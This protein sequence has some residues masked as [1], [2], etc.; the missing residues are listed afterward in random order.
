MIANSQLMN[1]QPKKKEGTLLMKKQI[2]IFVSMAA[3]VLGN[4]TFAFAENETMPTGENKAPSVVQEESNVVQEEMPTNPETVTPTSENI[5]TQDE[6]TEDGLPLLQPETVEADTSWFDDNPNKKEFKLSTEAQLLGLAQLVNT[7]V[8]EWQKNEAQTFKDCTIKLTK[9][10][11]LTEE[12]TPI[13][14]SEAYAFEGT[15]DGDG[16][17][18]NNVSIEN[19]TNSNVGFFGYLKG[20]A[21]N[22]SINGEITSFGRNIGGIAGQIVENATVENCI[23]NANVTGNN[24]VGGIVGYNNL[25]A[26]KETSNTGNI[27]GA[28]KVGGVVGENWGGTISESSNVGRLT[29]TSA[30]VGTYGTGGIAGRSV[31]ESAQIKECYNLGVIRSA[32]ECIGGVVGYVNAAGS[33]VISSYNT[34]SLTSTPIKSNFTL[35]SIGGVVG[36][37]GE[38]GVVLKNNYN[39]G[40]IKGGNNVGGILGTYIADYDDKITTYISNN[41]YLEDSAPSG[42]G[43]NIDAK[44][45]DY[46]GSLERRNARKF[47]SPRMAATLGHAFEA[48][49]SGINQKNKGFPVFKWQKDDFTGRDKAIKMMPKQYQKSINAFFE[50]NPYGIKAGQTII[51]ICNPDIKAQDSLQ[52]YIKFKEQ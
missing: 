30:G 15:F 38:D 20:T 42:V 32:N 46:N 11:D 36:T 10:I 1:N 35:I 27:K 28:F 29:S 25:G 21:I 12:W 37:Q 44:G 52:K 2:V 31:A 40:L 45:E 9:D 33:S 14:N 48:D 39:G 43:I 4:C 7:R 23:N 16:F 3:L 34:G 6:T 47:R 8:L 22:L 26:V 19:N 41:Y 51:Q 24:K 13:G 17:T 5:T 50:A 18:V 49:T